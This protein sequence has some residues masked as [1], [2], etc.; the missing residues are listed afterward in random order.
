MWNPNKDA[1]VLYRR[2][3]SA[4]PRIKRV[5]ANRRGVYFQRLINFAESTPPINQLDHIVSTWRA[6][7]HRH[8]ALQAAVFD[9]RRDHN[10]ARQMGFPC[11]HQVA[12]SPIGSNGADGLTVTGFY[13]TQTMFEKAYGNFLGLSRL[14]YFMSKQMGLELVE[15]TCIAALEKLSGGFTKTDLRTLANNLAGITSVSE[16]T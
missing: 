11:L 13:A 9:P 1:N 10:N 2:Y 8:S 14:G 4:W 16:G 12:F 7:N 3:D 6:G 5:P 15:V